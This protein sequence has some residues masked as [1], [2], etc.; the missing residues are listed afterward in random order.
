MF[1]DTW[2]E[3]TVHTLVVM[4]DWERRRELEA[5]IRHLVRL[6]VERAAREAPASIAEACGR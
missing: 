4:H 6:T 3:E 2:W 1:S 5:A